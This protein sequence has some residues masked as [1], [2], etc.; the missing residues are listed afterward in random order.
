MAEATHGGAH[1]RKRL[2]LG[3]VRALLGRAKIT[4]NVSTSRER[5][6][7]HLI[8]ADAWRVTHALLI[9][10]PNPTTRMTCLATE[11]TL[12]FLYTCLQEARALHGFA[13][14]VIDNMLPGNPLGTRKHR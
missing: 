3:H 13:S 1:G 7:R 8:Y 6:V 12:R 5:Y 4:Q 10:G 14:A 9:R 11:L 2:P